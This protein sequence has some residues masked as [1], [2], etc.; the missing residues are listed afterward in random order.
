MNADCTNMHTAAYIPIQSVRLVPS[1]LLLSGQ[2]IVKA[3]LTFSS[4][5]RSAS[6]VTW[7]SKLWELQR[8]GKSPK[9]MLQEDVSIFCLPP[10]ETWQDLGL[11]MSVSIKSC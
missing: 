10:L 1:F 4:D 3:V 2:C 5:A 11:H 7:T 8:G 9:Q 6:K